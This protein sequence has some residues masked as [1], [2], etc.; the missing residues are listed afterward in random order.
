MQHGSSNRHRNCY[1]NDRRRRLLRVQS[2]MNMHRDK[3]GL[4]FHCRCDIATHFVEHADVRSHSDAIHPDLAR[5][6]HGVETK[7]DMPAGNVFRKLY[8]MSVPG[9]LC[10]FPQ[11]RIAIETLEFSLIQPI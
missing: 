4:W 3:V 10:L 1:A 5:F 9:T 7:L 6:G 11:K 2:P 8:M